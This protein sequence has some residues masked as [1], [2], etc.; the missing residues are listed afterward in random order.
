MTARMA[1]LENS[2]ASSEDGN[3]VSA[4]IGQTSS[5]PD[6]RRQSQIAGHFDVIGRRTRAQQSARLRG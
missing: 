2:G 4:M 5:C 1:A 3:R 6:A